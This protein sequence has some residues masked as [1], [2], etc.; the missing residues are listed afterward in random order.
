MN[1]Y[2]IDTKFAS[3]TLIEVIHKEE[4][5]I[6]EMLLTYTKLERRF[7]YLSKDFANSDMNEGFDDIQVQ[8]K[9][10]KMVKYAKEVKLKDKKL[11]LQR[12][13][14]SFTAKKDSVNSLS[15]GLLQIAKQGISTIHGNLENCPNGREIGTESLKNIIWQGRNQAIHCEEGK[16]PKKV[17]DCF[18]KL[19]DKY[20]KDFDLTLH[21]T[22]NKA[23]KIIDLLEW[24]EYAQY[25]K[26]MNSILDKE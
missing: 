13:R 15:M 9:F 21:P 3:E 25:E 7:N 23:K 18:D 22:S 14:E 8:D 11:E 2:L 1:Q 10:I 12:I 16:P 17:K 19:K 26:D 4:K 6:I 24:E 5:L 20:G